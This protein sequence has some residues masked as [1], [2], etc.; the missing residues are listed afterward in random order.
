LDTSVP[1]RF[2]YTAVYCI[3]YRR[4][5]KKVVASFS[6]HVEMDK[7]VLPKN[8]IKT[9]CGFP[10]SLGMKSYVRVVYF[11]RVK[12][13]LMVKSKD[14]FRYTLIQVYRWQLNPISLPCIDEQ[15]GCFSQVT[16]QQG[17]QWTIVCMPSYNDG[18]TCS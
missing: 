12:G 14:T 3:P 17:S 5:H 4:H 10:P 16:T 2:E 11:F 8:K 15:T 1:H 13:S 7:R 18:Q 9:K 6:T